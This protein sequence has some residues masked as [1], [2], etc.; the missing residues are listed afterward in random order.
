MTYW[1]ISPSENNGHYAVTVDNT[2]KE[3]IVC[4]NNY[5]ESDYP[6]NWNSTSLVL[7]KDAYKCLRSLDCYDNIIYK[8]YNHLYYAHNAI[9][10][11]FLRKLHYKLELQFGDKVKNVYLLYPDNVASI[12][13]ENKHTRIY[14]PFNTLDQCIDNNVFDNVHVEEMGFFKT[15]TKKLL[16]DIRLD[17]L[18]LLCKCG[19][20]FP[21]WLTIPIFLFILIFFGIRKK[22][23]YKNR[24]IFY[25]FSLFGGYLLYIIFIELSWKDV[26]DSK[27]VGVYTIYTTIIIGLIYLCVD[28]IILVKKD[29]LPLTPYCIIFNSTPG[30]K[31]AVTLK[32]ALVDNGINANDIKLDLTVVRNDIF[33]SERALACVLSSQHCISIFHQEDLTVNDENQ[34]YWTVLNKS[35]LLHPIILGIEN[36]DKICVPNSIGALKKKRGG[37]FCF[38]SVFVYNN[39]ITQKDTSVIISAIMQKNTPKSKGCLIICLIFSILYLSLLFILE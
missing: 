14:V 37:L 3:L 24:F 20:Y 28:R 25:I 2:E 21:I 10:L 32:R 34:K 4:D 31:F 5:F 36:L 1:S 12:R 6:E 15:F 8:G 7:K 18:D 33:N 16:Y 13:C 39:E 19:F 17:H 38:P 29:K 22:E 30:K 27:W 9:E 26:I 35:K 23:N 11:T